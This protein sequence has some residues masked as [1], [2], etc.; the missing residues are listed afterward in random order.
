MDVRTGEG[1]YHE[2]DGRLKSKGK[3][4]RV[5][6]VD[7]REDGSLWVRLSQPLAH[8][9]LPSD[10]YAFAPKHPGIVTDYFKLPALDW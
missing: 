10:E 6:E 3:R 2:C 5:H 4:Q 7:V 9:P 8:D 1:V